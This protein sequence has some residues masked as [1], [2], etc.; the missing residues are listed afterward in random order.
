MALTALGG[1][2]AMA[3]SQPSLDKG[4]VSREPA[5]AAGRGASQPLTLGLGMQADRRMS[6]LVKG[7]YVRGSWAPPLQ[8]ETDGGRGADEGKPGVLLWFLEE[9]GQVACVSPFLML[10]LISPRLARFRVH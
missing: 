7:V 3:L 10:C 9:P 5:A 2:E 4:T 6:T 8:C 1:G